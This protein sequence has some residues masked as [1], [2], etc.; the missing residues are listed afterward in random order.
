MI[1]GIFQSAKSL[2]ACNKN[3]E[4]V[5]NNL[6]N[7]NTTGYKR[8]G[9]FSEILS[10]MTGPKIRSVVDTSQGELF[11]TS[12]P[13]DMAIN[14]E[15]LFVLQSENGYEFTR[16]GSFRISDEGFLVN[17]EGKKVIGKNGEIDLSSFLNGEDAK[18][19]VSKNGEIQVNDTPVSELLVVKIDDFEKRKT[20]LNFNATEN[21]MDFVQQDKYEILQGYLE[22]SNVNPILE[23]ENMINISKD[24]ESAYKMITY[25][26]GTLEKANE[27]G[28]L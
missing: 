7:I 13:L 20:G 23:M 17:E 8:E 28:K 3:M 2:Q 9:M 19:S 10:S 11:T 26:D 25:L 1:K 5:A 6:A 15:G 22:E 24:Y 21:I 18:I 4:K 12:N 14:G 16:N 27:L